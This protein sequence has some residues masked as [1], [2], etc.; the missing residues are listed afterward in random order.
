MKRWMQ[1]SIAIWAVLIA[2]TVHGAIWVDQVMSCTDEV[3][4]AEDIL[5]KRETKQTSGVLYKL[6]EQKEK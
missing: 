2:L 4:P 6:N 3:P 1:I 5:V